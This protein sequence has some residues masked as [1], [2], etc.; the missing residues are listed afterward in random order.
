M[1]TFQL[2]LESGD[3]QISMNFFTRAFELCIG[4]EAADE[5][6]LGR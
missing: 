1:E 6:E 5:L 3:A 4:W 2:V